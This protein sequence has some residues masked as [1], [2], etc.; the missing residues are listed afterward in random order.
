MLSK[1]PPLPLVLSGYCLYLPSIHPVSPFRNAFNKTV[2]PVS[3]KITCLEWLVWFTISYFA[4]LWGNMQTISLTLP[5]Q[6]DGAIVKSLSIKYWCTAESLDLNVSIGRW[7]LFDK[8]VTLFKGGRF[9]FVVPSSLWVMTGDW[10]LWFPGPVKGSGAFWPPYYA[11]PVLSEKLKKLTQCMK[12]ST[13]L[14]FSHICLILFHL[15]I[16]LHGYIVQKL[17]PLI[18]SETCFCICGNEAYVLSRIS[19]KKECRFCL[20]CEF[21]Q[22]YPVGMC[23][24]FLW[25]RR[26]SELHAYVGM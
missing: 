20:Y 18:L 5:W 17:L 3:L 16:S 7:L 19:Y 1:I 13:L 4:I 11:H 22:E 14:S 23:V 6:A 24:L 12:A 8:A 2:S 9:G 15:P 25:G 26:M 21:A 10:E